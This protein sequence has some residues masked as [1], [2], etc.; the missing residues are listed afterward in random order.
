METTGEWPLGRTFVFLLLC[1]I[2]LSAS[3]CNCTAAVG[4]KGSLAR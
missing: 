3:N 4:F 2:T 1:I